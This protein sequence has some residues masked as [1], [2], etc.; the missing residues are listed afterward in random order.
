VTT[1]PKTAP[2]SALYEG[3]FVALLVLTALVTVGTIQVI[4]FK[5]PVEASMG[6]VQKIFYFHVPAAYAMYVGAFACFVGSAGYLYDGRRTWDALARAGGEL[7]VGMGLIV[8]IT[9]PLWAAKAWGVYWTWDPRLT[10]SLLSVLMYVAYV[11]L[12][13][14]AG[15][16]DVENRFAAA[17]GVL[18]AANLPIIHFSVQKWGGNHPRVISSGGGG[19][20]HPDMKLA[21]ALGFVSFTL[22]AVLLLWWRV[23]VDLARMRLAELEHGALVLGLDEE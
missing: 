14:F 1:A 15:E 23:R 7:A 3:G 12:R 4:A 8:L 22:I 10:T 11:V 19:L 5:A 20:H 6:I 17:L 13:A 18:A 9:G 16:G 21:L 2:R